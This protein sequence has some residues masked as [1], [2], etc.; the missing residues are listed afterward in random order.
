MNVF[1]RSKPITMNKDAILKSDLLDILFDNRN[2]AYGAYELRKFYPERMKISLAILFSAVALLCSFTFLKREKMIEPDYS[3][4][5]DLIIKQ[6]QFD[7]N[8]PA[9]VKQTHVVKAKYQAKL[10]SSILLVPKK[11]SSD[12]IKDI[13]RLEI[14][15]TN[16]YDF[17]EDPLEVPNAPEKGNNNYMASAPPLPPEINNN[18]PYYNP[19]VQA[20]FPGGEKALIRF[21]ERNLQTPN[22]LENHEMI[23]VKIKFVVGFDGDLQSFTL[24]KDGGN[25]FNN[26]VIRVLKKMPKWNP[27]KKSGQN[28]PVYYTIPVKFTAVE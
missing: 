23:Q 5:N 6:V 19:D 10:L 18:Q 17:T 2:K 20:T 27:G 22:G 1:S 14:G 21:L 26:E 4:V 24:V 25:E 16:I 12:I 8:I 13:S 28:V 3:F 7:K 15:S 11:D 9:P